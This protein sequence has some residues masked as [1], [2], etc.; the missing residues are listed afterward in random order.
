MPVRVKKRGKESPLALVKRFN[1]AVKQSGILLRAKEI[2]FKQREKSEELKKEEALWRL[3]KKKEY[4][5]LK[6]LG[7]I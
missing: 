7:K 5:R 2:M 3:E 6:K 4:E 1:K